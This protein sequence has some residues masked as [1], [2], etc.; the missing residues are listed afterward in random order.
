MAAPQFSDFVLE[1]ANNPGTGQFVLD[2]AVAGRR[3]FSAA[4]PAGGTVFYY[5]DDGVLAEWGYGTLDVSGPVTLTRQ[6]VAGNTAETKSPV[7]F[8]GAVRVYSD[9]PATY[10]PVMGPDGVPYG[11]GKPL[12]LQEWVQKNYIAQTGGMVKSDLFVS[13]ADS[14]ATSS[15]G[16]GAALIDISGNPTAKA[17]LTVTNINGTPSGR[18]KFSSSGSAIDI[19]I[20]SIATRGWAQERLPI[21][22]LALWYGKAANVP[23]G[24]VICDGNNGTPD[25]RGLAIV[26]AASDDEVGTKTGSAK[27]SGGT[28]GGHALTVDEIPSHSHKYGYRS[29]SDSGSATRHNIVSDIASSVGTYATDSVGGGQ[30]HDHSLPE[31]DLTPPSMRIWVIMRVSY[32]D[33][34]TTT[35]GGSNGGTGSQAVIGAYSC[36]S[37]GGGDTFTLDVSSYGVFD[38]TLSQPTAAIALGAFNAEQGMA[39]QLQI[40]LHQGTGA[41]SVTWP[42]NVKWTGNRAPTLSL[43]IGAIDVVQLMTLDNGQTWLGTQ[44][45][46]WIT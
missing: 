39:R 28:T 30:E 11:G 27:W 40:V 7:N 2:G 17:T 34:D 12:A 4:F 32:P 35:G 31:I 29:W 24:W 6:I 15:P 36:Q 43:D 26:G 13:P 33:T 25:V 44:L 14:G 41:N 20:L 42:D 9:V 18:L 37:F 19:E 10:L 23:A 46:G 45:D 3:S 1:T 5:A 38:I 16:I 22:F 8:T 21:G